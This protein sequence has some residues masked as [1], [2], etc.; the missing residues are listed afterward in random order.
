MGTEPPKLAHKRQNSITEK[1]N[2]LQHSQKRR[3]RRLAFLGLLAAGLVWLVVPWLVN[4]QSPALLNRDNVARRSESGLTVAFYTIP[5]PFKNA[6]STQERAI[7]SWSI[8][9]FNVEINLVLSGD[10]DVQE[11]QDVASKYGASLFNVR[12]D[13]EGNVLVRLRDQ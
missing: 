9:P 3:F 1:Y 8:L 5:K 6:R 4:R 11:F 7:A 2:L 12:Q 13:P 10:S